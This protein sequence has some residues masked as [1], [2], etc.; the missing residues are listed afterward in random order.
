VSVPSDIYKGNYVTCSTTTGL[1]LQ[2]PSESVGIGE[3][4]TPAV[5]GD[6]ITVYPGGSTPAIDPIASP[7][8]GI[9]A[10]CTVNVCDNPT[11]YGPIVVPTV[12]K[13]CAPLNVVCLGPT[14]PVTVLPSG[15]V[16]PACA[17]LGPA[18]IPA[19][20]EIIPSDIVETPAIPSVPI[21]PVQTQEPALGP[22]LTPGVVVYVNSTPIPVTPPSTSPSTIGPYPVLGPPVPITLCDPNCSVP[23][24]IGGGAVEV[25]ASVAGRNVDYWFTV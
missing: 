15:S 9:P 13:T 14:D 1:I 23:V 24:T 10:T 20:P 2:V 3:Q 16:P 19:G 25:A 4:S 8:V 11:P 7:G 21:S 12:G 22:Q 17:V 6:T 18:C 5:G